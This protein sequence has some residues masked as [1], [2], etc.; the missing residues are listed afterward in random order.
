MSKCD[1]CQSDESPKP[2]TY[3]CKVGSIA[4]GEKVRVSDRNGREKNL[5]NPNPLPSLIGDNGTGLKHLDGKEEVVKLSLEQKSGKGV[6][7]GV[8]REDG[9]YE[10]S[11]V[12][13]DGSDAYVMI[14]NGEVTLVKAPTIL[15]KFEEGQIP[16]SKSGKVALIH[17]AEDGK[18]GLYKFTGC[19]TKK[20]LV[21]D[22]DG[23]VVCDE[24][25]DCSDATEAVAFSAIKAC[26]D[27]V[28]KFIKPTSD[29]DTVIVGCK[30]SYKHVTRGLSY[31]PVEPSEVWTTTD[32]VDSTSVSLA[33]AP[34]PVCEDGPVY[35]ALLVK[36]SAFRLNTAPSMA[37][38]LL[39]NGLIVATTTNVI[40]QGT[41]GDNMIIAKLTDKA[42]TAGFTIYSGEA[43]TAT[44]TVKASVTL[45][46]YYK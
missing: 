29:E 17:C 28:E 2:H 24:V 31:Y 16:G 19:G 42:F 34:D 7:I 39:I 18:V 44:N 22:A 25:S 14:K 45:L 20:A 1:C 13:S 11:V 35:A 40:Y 36:C 26:V 21:V 37:M 38:N 12:K 27:G 23:N 10:L 5:D 32:K 46:G 6:L 9:V 15:A 43:S 4:V 33:T 8:E 41:S 3:D 30:G